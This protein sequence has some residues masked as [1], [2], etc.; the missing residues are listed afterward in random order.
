MYGITGEGGHLLMMDIVKL[1]RKIP[2]QS[3]N[4]Y[5][6]IGGGDGGKEKGKGRRR[7]GEGE[8]EKDERRRKKGRYVRDKNQEDEEEGSYGKGMLDWGRLM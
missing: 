5:M 2:I 4:R 1:T 3:V 6:N 8:K 7:K